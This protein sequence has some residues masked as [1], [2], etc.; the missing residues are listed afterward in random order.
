MR[1]YVIFAFAFAISLAVMTNASAE[2]DVYMVQVDPSQVDNQVDEQVDFQGDCS[3]CQNE[4]DLSYFYWN[5][6]IDGILKEGVSA[7]EIMF[8]KMSSEFTK[9]SHDITLQVRDNSQDW[10][11][12]DSESTTGLQV[13]GKDGSSDIEVN[14]QID[15]P[16]VNLGESA[17]FRACEEMLPDPLPCV[18]DLSLQLS[19]D[20]DIMVEGS[21]VWEDLGNEEAFTKSDFSIGNHTVKLVIS[22][23]DGDSSDPETAQFTVNPPLPIAEISGGSTDFVVKE[24]QSLTISGKCYDRFMAVMDD[25]SYAWELRKANGNDLVST[26]NSKNI[27]LTDLLY[28]VQSY[29]LTLRVTD[30]DGIASNPVQ[31]MI[32]VNPP[33]VVPTG[34]ITVTPDP[35]GSLMASE[36]YK[37]MNVSFDASSSVDPDG[38]L[39]SHEWFHMVGQDWVSVSQES[40][41]TKSFDALSFQ[42][43]KLIVKDDNGASSSPTSVSIKIIENAPPTVTLILSSENGT[44]SFKSNVSDD[45]TIVS[46]AWYVN[47]ILTSE[48]QN[49]TWIPNASGDY[50]VKLV[51]TDNGGAMTEVSETIAVSVNVPKNFVATFSSKEIEVGGSVV[52]NFTETT[53]EVKFFKITVTDVN[54][55]SD[56]VEYSTSETIYSVKFTKAGTY[57][58]DVEVVWADGIAQ[59]G[60]ADWYGP[61]I[62]VGD[63]GSSSTPEAS[64]DNE[65]SLTEDDLPSITF[66][67]ALM[68]TSLVA[69]TRRQR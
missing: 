4:E 27:S 60:L 59:S 7:A 11:A 18:D 2:P 21:D 42:Y 36:Y 10:S 53:G 13:D 32:M 67:A 41:W 62:K 25:C 51:V 34:V 54:S 38:Q 37:G 24:G 8:T 31:A 26:F 48:S 9:G 49:T 40:V 16:L 52:I 45:G 39:V 28:E 17:S 3:I 46:F 29:R 61:T 20:W 5:S 30:S 50:V 66:V 1:S 23:S 15:P 44:H 69:I 35:V 57:T 47:D 12:I 65:T 63:G 64:G 58:M 14:F 6:S 19:F 68:A 56:K 22:T 55:P 43:I 33:N